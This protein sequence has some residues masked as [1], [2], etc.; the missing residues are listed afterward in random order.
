MLLGFPSPQASP[1]PTPQAAQV[2][3]QPPNW[4]LSKLPLVP[5]HIYQRSFIHLRKNN[6]TPLLWVL[7]LP[8][9][10]SYLFHESRD[11]LF[12][13]TKDAHSHI[14]IWQGIAQVEYMNFR[15]LGEYWKAFT[16]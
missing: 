7:L 3:Q 10:K 6:S 9:I 16:K 4:T 12:W 11:L 15:K 13:L 8:V 2:L 14:C 1:I 5:R